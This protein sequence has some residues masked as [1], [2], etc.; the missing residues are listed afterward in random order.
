MIPYYY[1]SENSVKKS[2][3]FKPIK[4]FKEDLPN[5]HS[6][7]DPQLRS[8]SILMTEDEDLKEMFSTVNKEYREPN[9]TE[10]IKV[11]S[12][13][14]PLKP[15][16]QKPEYHTEKHNSKRGSNDSPLLNDQSQVDYNYKD[17]FLVCDHF[18]IKLE[19]YIRGYKNV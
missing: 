3:S 5:F 15:K 19:E 8:S 10:K 6:T 18:L 12:Y 13:K 4:S 9:T 7:Y 1:D 11:K 2:N 14:P 16:L 17:I